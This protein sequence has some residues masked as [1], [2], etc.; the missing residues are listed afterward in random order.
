MQWLAF[1]LISFAP[2][3]FWLWFF[4]KRHVY[5]PGPKRLLGLTFFLGMVS[6]VPAGLLSFAFLGDLAL[7]SS[8]DLSRVAAGMLFVVGPVE[9][10]SKFLSVRLVAYRSLYFDE[11]IDGLVYSASASLGFASLENLL[12]V[13][14]F[15]PSVMIG[16][17]PIS[18]V[19]HVVFGSFWGYALG[20]QAQR[21]FQR[22]WIALAVGI[23]AAAIFHGLFNTAIFA[24]WPIGLALVGI[25][26]WWTLSRFRWAQRVSPFR[27][28]RNYPR[29]ACTNCG[30]LISILGRFCRQCGTP[31]N[32][33]P[34]SDLYCSNCGRRNRSDASFCTGCG[35]NLLR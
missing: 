14:E 33:P 9:E 8:A 34:Y 19:A 11:P 35:D 30:Q 1:P 18:T 32:A 22:S 26:I 3:I 17:A 15:G 25:G 27:Y 13:T 21:E 7:D 6:T 4:A 10:T 31:A 12:Y 23:G 20:R 28:R 2:G 29:V 16:R 5:R 24:F